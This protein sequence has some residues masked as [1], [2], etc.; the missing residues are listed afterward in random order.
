MSITIMRQA[1]TGV[2]GVPVTAYD[3]NGEVEPRVT[4]KVY[5]RVAVAGIPRWWDP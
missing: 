5:D 3:G 4:A 2:S 1:L